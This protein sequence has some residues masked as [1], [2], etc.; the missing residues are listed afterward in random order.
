MYVHTYM[1][2]YM[3]CAWS[4]M[5]FLFLIAAVPLTGQKNS[6]YS[7]AI[8]DSG[9]VL[10]SGGTEKVNY[11]SITYTYMYMYLRTCIE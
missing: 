11:A 3:L 9:T 8:N 1:Y 5:I 6:I 2:M 4:L 7:L 10:V